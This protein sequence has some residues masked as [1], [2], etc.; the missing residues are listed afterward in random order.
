M[1][2]RA[3]TKMKRP[4]KRERESTDSSERETAAQTDMVPFKPHQ[5]TSVFTVES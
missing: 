1:K 2:K 5:P 4:E 3:W